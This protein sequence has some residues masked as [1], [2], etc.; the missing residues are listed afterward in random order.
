MKEYP[1][2]Y[3]ILKSLK[4]TQRKRVEMAREKAVFYIKHKHRCGGKRQGAEEGLEKTNDR[5]VCCCYLVK[6]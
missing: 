6:V 5:T 4:L 2:T 3:L 1:P